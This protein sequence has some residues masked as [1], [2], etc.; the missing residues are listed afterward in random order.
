MKHTLK[1][2]FHS[3]RFV[4]GFTIFMIMLLTVLIYPYIITRDPLAGLGKQF[5]APGTY[6]SV[7]D[8]N[9]TGT[10]RVELP[11]AAL[12]RMESSVPMED[13]ETILAFLTAKGVDVSGLDTSND[14]VDDL[15]AL[16]KENYDEADVKANKYEGFSTQAK[17]YIT[18][19]DGMSAE[20]FMNTGAA[21]MT[22]EAA[23]AQHGQREEPQGSFNG[24]PPFG[25][26]GEHGGRPPFGPGGPGGRP[27]FPPGEGRPPFDGKGRPPMPPRGEPPHRK[28]EQESAKQ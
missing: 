21:A 27:P 13:R 6:V 3:P 10:Y 19:I 22:L 23:N 25:S 5:L 11:D 26:G 1:N 8:I 2:I 20:D 4:V 12:K 16:W 7:Y 28:R 18:P 9:N 17:R 15:L 14:K 24:K